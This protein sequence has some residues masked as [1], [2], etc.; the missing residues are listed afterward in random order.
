[1]IAMAHWGTDGDDTEH[2]RQAVACLTSQDGRLTSRAK[3]IRPHRSS[4]MINDMRA[5]QASLFSE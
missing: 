1:M 3:G 5:V 2:A 4:A